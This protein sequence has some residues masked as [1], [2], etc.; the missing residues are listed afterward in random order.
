MTSFTTDSHD[1]LLFTPGPL[2]TSRT[3]KQA[4]L[5]DLGS[6]DAE[7][8]EIVRNIRYRLLELGGVKPGEYEAILMQGSGTFAVE[9]AISS[10][11]PPDGKLLV[12]INGAYGR[13]IEQIARVLKIDCVALTFPEDSQ[14][15]LSDIE[16]ALTADQQITHVAVI[17]CETTTGLVNPIEPIGLLAQKH[18]KRY[19]VD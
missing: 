4:M 19:L 3:V 1:K 11:I 14:P 17:H 10:T 6:R 2:T 5:R 16:A 12:I 7:F 9:S 8:V 15:A 18:G 13:R